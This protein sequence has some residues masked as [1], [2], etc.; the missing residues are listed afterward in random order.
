MKCSQEKLRRNGVSRT[1]T[2]KDLSTG[3]IPSLSLGQIHQA[4]WS[5]DCLTLRQG[6]WAFLFPHSQSLAASH[7][8][9]DINPQA[10]LALCAGV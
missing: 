6:H 9:V 5:T 3:V 10:F 2:G 1:R 7:L 8:R 4:S